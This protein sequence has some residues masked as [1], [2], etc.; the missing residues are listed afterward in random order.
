M[1]FILDQLKKSGKQRALEMAMHRQP[2]KPGAKTDEPQ[3]VQS[4]ARKTVSTKKWQF[5]AGAVLLGAVALYGAIAFFRVPVPMR[6]P[7][8]PVAKV[9]AH[10]ASQLSA[11]PLSVPQV[12]TPGVDVHKEIVPDIISPAIKQKQ[13]GPVKAVK[14]ETAMDRSRNATEQTRADRPSEEKGKRSLGVLMDAPVE[15]DPAASVPE[16]K[17]LPQAVRKTI[18]EIRITSHLYKKDT[19]LVS[20]NGRIMS[21]GYNMDDGLFLEEIVP[22]GVIVSYGKHRFLVR[23]ER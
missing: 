17:Q 11:K 3:L 2:E 16:Y 1:S 12:R 21:E 4:A 9:L 13:A 15:A 5:A 22:E 23:A 14:L 19:S 10:E 7:V 6:Q 20:I 18:P 8:V